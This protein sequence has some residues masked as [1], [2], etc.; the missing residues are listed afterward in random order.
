MLSS[1]DKVRRVIDQEFPAS[2]FGFPAVA[3]N[4][5]DGDVGGTITE[6]AR[7]AACLLT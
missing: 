5:G 3:K 6:K 1:L 7:T 4:G 2:F